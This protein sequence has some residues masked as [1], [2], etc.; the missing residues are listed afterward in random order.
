MAIYR[1]NGGAGESTQDASITIV[2][3]KALEATT[4]SSAAAASAAAAAAAVIEAADASRLTIGTVITGS[5]G[6]PAVVTISGAAGAQ[7][8]SFTVPKGDQGIQ[9][10][11]GPQGI[12]G[13]QG[14]QG[15]VGPQGIQGIQGIQGEVGPQGIQGETG[16][17]GASFS[18]TYLQVSTNTLLVKNTASLVDTT[19]S[20]I[21]LTL[22]ASP[23]QGDQVIIAD[24]AYTF[25]TN[26]VIVERNG[27]TIQGYDEDLTINID[28]ALVTLIYS[29]A[30]WVVYAVFNSLQ[31]STVVNLNS[32]QTLSNKT[33]VNPTV[34][35][36]TESIVE[37]GTVTSAHTFDLTN[38]SLQIATLTANTLCTFTMPTVSVGTSFLCIIKQPS[39]TGGGTA[40]FT[41]VKWQGGEAP[42]VTGEVDKIDLF[43]FLYDGTNWYGAKAQDYQ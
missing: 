9:G 16:P 24:K 5:A 38:G 37:I 36:Y 8:L 12:Q 42:I 6:T 21:T 39:V 30:T 2:P 25:A 10:E 11:I 33:L 17:D 41:G 3:E 15:E 34:R 43:S 26:N 13:I 28:G 22:P 23:S 40:A 18:L 1:G 35:Q 32:T 19:S 4:A 14:I 27:S 29:G 31:D 20:V 7:T